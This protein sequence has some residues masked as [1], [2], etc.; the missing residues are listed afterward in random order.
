MPRRGGA[1]GD[2]GVDDA[3][4][5][6]E[7]TRHRVTI[8]DGDASI[9]VAEDDTLLGCML[10]A[11]LG[12]PYECNAGGCGSCKFTLVEGDLADDLDDTPGLRNADRR[13]NKHLA[14]ISRVRGDCVIDVR[15]DPAYVPRIAPRRRQ[16]LFVSR[17]ALTHDLWEFR[18][19]TEDRAEFLPGQYAKLHFPE[20]VGPRSY[21]MSNTAN[22]DGL[23]CFQIKRVPGGAATTALFERDLEGCTA[24]LDGPYSI[25]HLDA[26]SPRRVICIAG[27]SGLAPMVSILRGLAEAGGA[28]DEASLYYGARTPRDVVD[29]DYFASIPGFDSTRQYCPVV[30]E[31]DDDPAWAGPAGFLH[32]HLATALPEDC[33]ESDFY[34]A[35]PPP[36]VDAVRRHLVLDRGVPVER[37]HYDRFF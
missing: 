20:I 14:C 7:T 12:M 9:E 37:L 29:P 32:E 24:I 23:W 35:G 22:A 19:K 21:S 18:F 15:L 26:A 36:M 13:K 5:L 11:G 31:A 8:A 3:N 27:G 6:P 1:A 17:E 10:R 34:I 16:A 25:A 33:G 28:I 30:S 4:I 2:T